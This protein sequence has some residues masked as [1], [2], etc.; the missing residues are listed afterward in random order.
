MNIIEESKP[1]IMNTYE[2]TD[3]L[4]TAPADAI[5]SYYSGNR[6]TVFCTLHFNN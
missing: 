4:E 6:P 2:I 1:P 5:I 3:P